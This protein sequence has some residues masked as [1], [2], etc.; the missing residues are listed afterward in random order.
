[1]KAQRGY[2]NIFTLSLTSSLDGWLVK[3][4]PWPLYLREIDPVT[5]VWEA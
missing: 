2:S 3:A 5:V 4:T 1:M